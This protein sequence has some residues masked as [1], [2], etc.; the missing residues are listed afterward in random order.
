MEFFQDTLDVRESVLETQ[1]DLPHQHPGQGLFTKDAFIVGFPG[2]WM[3]GR[4]FGTKHDVDGVYA[5]SMTEEWG[6]MA[7]LLYATHSKCQ[8]NFIN[9]GL[10]G[11]KVLYKYG[12]H[13]DVNVLMNTHTHAYVQSRNTTYT[14]THRRPTHVQPLAS[15]NVRF[16]FGHPTRPDNMHDKELKHECLVKVFAT[17]DIKAGEELYGTYGNAFWT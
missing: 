17:K 16:A 2:Y 10:I 6:G 13:Y 3:E 7:G 12:V 8:A 14:N 11:D 15:L 5:F 1:K 4:V 9:S